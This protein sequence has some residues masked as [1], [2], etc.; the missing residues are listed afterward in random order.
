MKISTLSIGDELIY[1]E[2]VDTNASRIAAR[3]YDQG[4]K[5]QRH[6]LVGDDE[7]AIID[8]LT[9]LAERSEVVVVTGGLGPTSDDL[10]AQAAA[11]AA[12]QPLVLNEEA[13]VR[14]Q[15]FVSKEGGEYMAV[16]RRQALLPADSVLIPNPTGTASGFIITWNSC[17]LIFLPGVPSEM[18]RM[19]DDT[20]LPFILGRVVRNRVVKT[21]VFTL[22]GISEAAMN[23]HL[24]DLSDP[25]NQGTSLALAF[26][27][28][29]PTIELKLRGEGE[30]DHAVVAILESAAATVRERLGEYIVA[31]DGTSLDDEVA[32]ALREKK[33]TLSLAESCTGGFIA[34]R[35]TD[36]AG[37]S[38]YFLEGAV[39]YSNRAKSR[40]LGVPEEMIV[41]H[42]AVS[43]EVAEAMARGER[44][45]AG[46]DLALAVTGVAGP[47]ASEEKPAGMVFIA[48]ADEKGCEVREYLFGGNRQQVRMLTTTTA[49][50]W[51][52][53]YLL[54]R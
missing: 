31:E 43:R 26:C 49:L 33:I 6:E 40:L 10:T 28:S 44:I 16:T 1:G 47:G 37:S 52:R 11:T 51:I 36:L 30:S 22:F 17:R 13:L 27:V 21:K 14:M 20:V 54:E 53:R 19:L 3:L 23:H 48:L 34:K 32:R 24:T 39:V 9:H 41:K 15:A 46:S 45:S 29:F 8:A 18:I 4:L 5:V 7:P 35:I 2:V 25:S 38:S 42:G 12:G 50:D